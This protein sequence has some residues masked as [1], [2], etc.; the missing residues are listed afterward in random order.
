M[1]QTVAVTG[2]TGFVGRHLVGELRRCGLQV[3]GLVRPGANEAA[4]PVLDETVAGDLQ[5]H[6]AVK[7][8]VHGAD[9]VI[10]VAGAIAGLKKADFFKVNVDGTKNIVDA[11]G[12]SGVARFIFVSSLA[13]REPQISSYA[14][15]KRQGEDVVRAGFAGAGGVIVRP[16]ALY[17]PGDRATLI[18]FKQLSGRRA[19]ISGL[20]DQAISWM[21]VTDLARALSHLATCKNLPND[22]LELDDGTP[23]GYS[24]PALIKAAG[25]ARGEEIGL[26]LLPRWIVAPAAYL[27]LVKSRITGKADVFNPQKVAEIYHRDWVARGGNIAGWKPEIGFEQGCSQTLNWYRENGWL[28]SRG[29]KGKKPAHSCYGDQNR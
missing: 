12:A 8:L 4:L 27:S 23:G 1:A 6:A 29:S 21:H 26:T 17:G 9:V 25:R 22:V 14:A 18:L 2:V 24:W 3:R 15:S 11:A 19:F 10:H 5:D 20:K 16:P 28:P 13:A 7:K